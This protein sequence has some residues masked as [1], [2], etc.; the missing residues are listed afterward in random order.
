MSIRSF[1][2]G[3]A[4][5]ALSFVSAFQLPGCGNEIPDDVFEH[6]QSSTY[7]GPKLF[8]PLP[9]GIR[10]KV[11]TNPG[12]WSL[13]VTFHSG[14]YHHAID[15]GDNFYVDGQFFDKGDGQI[16][17]LAAAD[18]KVSLATEA[19]DCGNGLQNAACKVF[20]NHSGSSRRGS[21]Y[22]TEYTHLTPGTIVVVP[23]QNVVRGQKLGKMGWSGTE[24]PHL[25]FSIRYNND[26]S[27]N[28]PALANV[29]LEDVPFLD[30]QVDRF[31]PSTNG[32]TYNPANNPTLCATEPTGGASTNWVYS[33]TPKTVFRTKEPVWGMFRIDAIPHDFSYRAEVRFGPRA[34]QIVNTQEWQATGV[35]PWGWERSY[36]W[37]WVYPDKPGN[38]EIRYY[39][40]TTDQFPSF[41]VAKAAFTVAESA[42]FVHNGNGV[43]CNRPPQGGADT[44]WTY[45]CPAVTT[46]NPYVNP[47]V[48][49]MLYVENINRNFKFI[50]HVYKNGQLQWKDEPYSYTV[51]EPWV[52]SRAYA[53]PQARPYDV[54][55]WS[56][57]VYL[58]LN[59]GKPAIKLKE[60]PFTV[61]F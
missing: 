61:T 50:T 51:V 48:Y 43:V 57:H 40:K 6:R 24:S 35:D 25:H 7:A 37:P 2:G 59:D 42:P 46:I 18:G 54:G 56:F 19:G 16:D 41:P 58:Q 3:I 15:F 44:N 12:F 11:N 28:N 49:G 33:C 23:G 38:W 45:T 1:F 20:I 14:V 4:M 27:K 9:A 22:E 13:L 32:F 30:Y 36:F 17:V 55:N 31:Y 5:I 53:F 21:G 26:S 10:W 52:W 29:K 34:E 60:I 47:T 39:V 8:M